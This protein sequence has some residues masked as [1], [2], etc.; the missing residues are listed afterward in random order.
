M[1]NLIKSIEFIKPIIE[2]VILII[3]FSKQHRHFKLLNFKPIFWPYKIPINIPSTFTF[4]ISM[5]LPI[6]KLNFPIIRKTYQ[7]IKESSYILY[8][9]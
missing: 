6:I 9:S 3:Y 5:Q 4:I 7:L 2:I 1:R 8:F